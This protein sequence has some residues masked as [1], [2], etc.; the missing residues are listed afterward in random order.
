VKHIRTVSLFL[1]A[2]LLVGVRGHQLINAQSAD[3]ARQDA[4]HEVAEALR[5][6]Q[7][8]TA[9][10]LNASASAFERAIAKW[11]VVGDRTQLAAGLRGLGVVHRMLGRTKE[12]VAELT[13]AVTLLSDTGQRALALGELASSFLIGG[14]SHKALD[15]Y[16]DALAA[17]R[18]IHDQPGEAKVLNNIGVVTLNLGESHRAIDAFKESLAKADADDLVARGNTLGNLASAYSNIGDIAT[19]KE[20]LSQS[21]DIRQA[22]SDKRGLA[23]GLYIL[24]NIEQNT[25][26]PQKALAHL[27]D[28][29]DL[30]RATGDRSG[31][32][33]SVQTLGSAYQKLGEL[34]AALDCFEQAR[35]IRHEIGNRNAEADTLMHIADAHERLGEHALA[36]EHAEQ[37]LHLMQQAGNPRGEGEA[38]VVLGELSRAGGQTHRALEYLDRALPLTSASNDVGS[39]MRALGVA[40]AAHTDLGEARLGLDGLRQAV[41]LAQQSRDRFG[42]IEWLFETARAHARLGDLLQARW[43]AEQS[44]TAAEG[45]RSDLTGA[46][47]RARYFATVRH[48]YDL[49]IDTLMRLDAAQPGQGLRESAFEVSERARAR[50]LLDLLSES[51]VDLR[52]GLDAELLKRERDLESALAAK[53]QAVVQLRVGPHSDAEAAATGRELDA[54]TTALRELEAEIRLR[55]PHYAALTQPSIATLADV[56]HSLLD[57]DTVLVEFDLGEERSYMW[58]VTRSSIDARSLPSRAAIE[59]AVRRVYSLISVNDPASSADVARRLSELGTLLMGAL[60]RSARRVVVVPD[61]ALEYLPFGALL[62]GSERPLLS[63]SEVMTLP[64][65]STLATLRAERLGG[66]RPK[67][68]K[69]IAAIA[70]PV[71]DEHDPR[72]THQ[73]TARAVNE[74]VGGADAGVLRSA[75]ESGLERLER[76]RFSRREADV[77][78]SLVPQDQRLTALDF[79]ASR[80]TMLDP[81]LGDYRIVHIATHGLIN[82]RHPELSGLV[83]SLVNSEG[84]AQDGFVKSYELYKLKLNADLV[85]LSACQTALGEQVRGE[86]LISLTRPFMY[87]G[88]PRVV[89]SLWE[90]PD[91][92]SAAL[93]DLFYQGIVKEHLAAAAALRRAQMKLRDT[94]QWSSPYF[95]AGFVLQ[96]DWR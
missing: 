69:F 55:S 72:V 7:L 36:I 90:V 2:I 19:A 10:A 32:A 79:D 92:A 96:G 22:K 88:V 58:L 5:L 93:M 37:A 59:A 8:G 42:E 17:L 15:M 63:R 43:V 14:D 18:E 38:L 21:L 31:E 24:G 23:A 26:E 70:D 6:R 64:S 16:E 54:L 94:P 85:V 71:F 46:D 87:A 9:D 47:F 81:V 77:I 83:L 61:G 89:A 30:R 80:E 76:L 82:S 33:Y 51:R 91:R 28:S 41:T 20:F 56:Q 50:S 66:S 67:A 73:S 62:S 11:R 25:G 44:V 57:D 74:T 34:S 95:W 84:R 35:R 1:V 12:S 3:T 27:K 53:T 75:A 52:E 49:L 65:A 40:A 4:E 29:V 78:R 45:V 13:E 68:S 60:P 86:G 39:Q 48:A